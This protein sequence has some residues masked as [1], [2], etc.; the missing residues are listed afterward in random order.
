[1]SSQVYY[2]KWTRMSW[3]E[4]VRLFRKYNMIK[5]DDI[6]RG[7]QLFPCPEV[8]DSDFVKSQS[9]KPKSKEEK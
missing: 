1:M 5:Y 9:N 3:F 4:S 6:Q 8:F 2:R 7:M